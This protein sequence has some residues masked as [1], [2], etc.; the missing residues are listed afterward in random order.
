MVR[1]SL[2]NLRIEHI[3]ISVFDI[4]KMAEWYRKAFQLER[5]GNLNVSGSD[6]TITVLMH[7][8]GTRVEIL[9]RPNSRSGP[10]P[11]TPAEAAET[12][13][14]GHFAFAVV[15]VDGM[16]AHLVANGAAPIMHPTTGPRDR[17]RIAF[18][19]DPEGNLIELICRP[20]E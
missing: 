19:A 10:V 20:S 8:S 18:V 3:G 17:A 4:E 7:P 15:D 11:R 12:R 6:L 14:Y 9:H 13:G 2:E 1:E 5:H 16:F